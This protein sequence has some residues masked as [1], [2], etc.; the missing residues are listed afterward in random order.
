MVH[1]CIRSTDLLLLPGMMCDA[2]LWAAQLQALGS[3]CAVTVGDITAAET[4]E[5]IAAQVL[6][7]AP[8]SFALAGL[9]MGGIVALEMWR[10]APHRIERLAMLDSNFRADP[11]ERQQLRDRQMAEVTA[12]GLVRVL[13]EELKPNYLAQ[14]HRGNTALLDEVLSM[15]LALGAEVFRRQSLALRDRPDSTATLPTITC[16]AL[17][18]CGDED[19]LCPPELHRE[20]AGAIPSASLDIIAECGHLSAMEQPDAVNTAMLR[21]LDPVKE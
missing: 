6:D 11:P 7:A 2:Q 1:D 15:G 3:H 20:M 5:D 9:S 14:C 13:R 17:V 8:P 10:Q 18:L 19:G 21:W 4:V 16:P 12:G